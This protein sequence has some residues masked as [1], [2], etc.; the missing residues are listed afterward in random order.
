MKIEIH[1]SSE[2][3]V[4]EHGWLHSK[5]SF[6]FAD[7]YNPNRMGFGVLRVINEDIVEP[8]RGFGAHSHDN[9]EIVSIVLDGALEH[10]DSMG[11]HGIIP[12]GDIQRMSAGT[13]VTHSEFNHSKTDAVHFLQIWVYPR[14]RNIKPSYE[15]R[16]FPPKLRKNKLLPVVSGIK[17][18]GSVYIHQ[19]AAFL[20]GSLDGGT[21]VS[22]RINSPE[23]GVYVFVIRGG[24]NIGGK[25]LGDGDAAGITDTDVV[26]IKANRETD[27]LV[28]EVPYIWKK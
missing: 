20:I 1:P 23:H 21:A 5:H 11:N 27:V 24:I 16:S 18:E 19:D 9:M 14:E 2:R 6:S 13:G 7:Y 10:K 8:G 4:A 28:I 22:H 3:G 12:A 26:K 15:Q 25:N 17:S